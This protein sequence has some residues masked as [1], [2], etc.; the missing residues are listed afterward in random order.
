MFISVYKG[1]SCSYNFSLSRARIGAEDSC[2]GVVDGVSGDI[3]AVDVEDIIWSSGRSDVIF[4]LWVGGWVGQSW[5]D[6]RLRCAGME[7][8]IAC[9]GAEG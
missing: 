3:G 6:L 2:V 8:C 9:S 4:L 7:L 5:G 1:S